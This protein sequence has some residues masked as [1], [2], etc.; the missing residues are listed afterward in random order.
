MH[1]RSSL[2]SVVFM[3]LIS[4]TQKFK[5]E[6]STL[7]TKEGGKSRFEEIF[8]VMNLNFGLFCSAVVLSNSSELGFDFFA[9]A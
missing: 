5:L 1:S 4:P 8:K 9:F 2:F 3:C 6:K 7:N